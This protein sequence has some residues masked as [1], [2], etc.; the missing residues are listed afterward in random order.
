MLSDT[1]KRVSVL[2]EKALVGTV[3]LMD[4]VEGTE[5][6]CDIPTQ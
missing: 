2:D 4:P 1:P 3:F 6:P 5:E